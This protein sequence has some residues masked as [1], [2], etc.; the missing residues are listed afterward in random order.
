MA[1]LSLFCSFLTTAFP[2]E[3]FRHG[4]LSVHEADPSAFNSRSCLSPPHQWVATRKAS[5][6][7][8]FDQLH[9]FQ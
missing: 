1:L 8:L 5:N 4:C 3:Q 6:S 2:G 9:I 7:S